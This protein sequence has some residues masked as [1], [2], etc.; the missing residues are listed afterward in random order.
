MNWTAGTKEASQSAIPMPSDFWRIGET[1]DKHKRCSIGS[2]V[3]EINAIRVRAIFIDQRH[4]AGPGMLAG[5][6][7]MIP[8]G[9]VADLLI[10]ADKAIDQ[11][12][13]G[14]SAVDVYPRMYL[15]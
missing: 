4:V 14:R 12:G 6:P 8:F 3:Y 13:S 7:S 15:Q 11:I 1:V 2:K 10:N 9:L 5:R